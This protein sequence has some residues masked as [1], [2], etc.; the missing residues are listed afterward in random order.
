[1]AC[2]A[3]PRFRIARRSRRAH[4]A[5]P[6]R[7][8]HARRHRRAQLVRLRPPVGA[9][10]G[11][12]R[13]PAGGRAVRRGA[14]GQAT[15][16]RGETE[17]YDSEASSA[18]SS[19]VPT[20]DS[21]ATLRRPAACPLKPMTEAERLVAD[22]AGTGL[23]VGRHPMALRRDELAM[24]GVLRAIDLAHGAAGPARARRRHG[25]HAAAAGHGKG[26]VFLTLEDETGIANIIVRPGSVRAR[27]AGHRRR[28]VSARRRRAAEPGR[29]HLGAR[30]AGAGHARR[31]HRF[32]RPRLLLMARR[33]RA[34][35]RRGVQ[36]KPYSSMPSQPPFRALPHGKMH[37]EDPRGPSDYTHE[38]RSAY[39]RPP[40]DRLVVLTARRT[41]S[42]VR[43]TAIR[44][45]GGPTA[46]RVRHSRPLAGP[47]GRDPGV[48]EREAPFCCSRPAEST[49]SA[50]ADIG[51]GPALSMDCERS[52][53]FFPRICL[54]ADGSVTPDLFDAV[55]YNAMFTATLNFDL[56]AESWARAHGK[57]LVGQRRRPPA[58]SARPTL[59]LVARPAW[60]PLRRNT[61]TMVLK[62]GSEYATALAGA[63]PTAGKRPGCRG[64][65][66]HGTLVLLKRP[67]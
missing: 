59:S 38:S 43:G 1:M 49:E 14:D 35:L 39:A 55:E 24:R 26:F 50:R 19:T 3:P 4:R 47:R 52:P 12:T 10:A 46:T 51:D 7:S 6:R 27:S 33:G 18:T 54:R 62:P 45:R 36:W 57:P 48:D 8:R 60:C 65:R 20:P 67:R 63:V 28:A 41:A 13:R 42:T 64:R 61:E 66:K 22:Y 9:L 40:H 17:D 16:G 23:T 21:L 58:A 11:R 34:G 31:R 15:A 37:V 56:R 2:S 44:V 30:R 5:A 32:R 25:H 29:R 53:P